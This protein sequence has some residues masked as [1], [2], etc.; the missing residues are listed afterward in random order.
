MIKRCH[1]AGDMLIK[2]CVA[3]LM[4]QRSGMLQGEITSEV[5]GLLTMTTVMY[6][7]T[8]GVSPT[9]PTTMT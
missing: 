5:R 1:Q 9:E 2:C 6:G 4:L 7:S 3:G 8:R